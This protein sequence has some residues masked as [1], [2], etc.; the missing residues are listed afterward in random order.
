MK[1]KERIIFALDVPTLKE[2]LKLTEELYPHIGMFKVG[3]ELLHSEGTPRVVRAI[4]EKG[5]KVLVDAKLHD[6]P[7]TV[8][9][10]ARAIA[11]LD[12]EMFT[13]HASGSTAMI[14]AAVENEGNSKALG[15]TVLTSIG[16]EECVSIF[17]SEPISKVLS[18]ATMLLEAKASGIICSPQEL[19]ALCQ[20]L[21]SENL[22]KFT[23][24]IRPEWA[25]TKDQ[26]RIM[27]PGKAIELGADYLVIG[28]PIREPPPEIGSRIKAA[29]IIAEEI[30]TVTGEKP[31]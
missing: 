14:K 22:L 12:A 25:A 21:G 18:F 26:K 6:I 24:G 8:A 4:Q 20:Q 30:A 17:G 27:T 13:I 23:P 19:E 31:W 9:G 3:L 2:A 1:A 7:N 11:K 16:E 28:R 29:R 15:V 5:G 10:A